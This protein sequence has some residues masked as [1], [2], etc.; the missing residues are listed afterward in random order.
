MVQAVDTIDVPVAAELH[1]FRA[2]VERAF[3]GRLRGAVLF[4]S[5]ARGEARDDSD[6]DVALFIDG[7]D[8]G[9]ES[10]RLN[11]LAVPYHLR[12]VVVSPLG[13]PADR[14]GVSPELL[15]NIDHDGMPL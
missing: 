7:F 10:R 4:G 14:H 12:G 1:Q 9:R 13:I 11:L 5:R 6:W 8:R 15:W 3:P 2:D